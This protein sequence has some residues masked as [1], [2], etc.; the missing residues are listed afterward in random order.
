MQQ[1]HSKKLFQL[2]AYPTLNRWIY[3][4]LTLSGI[5]LMFIV[6]DRMIGIANL[7]LALAFDPFNPK[8]T[9]K[10]RPVYQKRWLIVHLT[11]FYSL[12]MAIFFLQK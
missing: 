12:F 2:L 7:G 3:V 11:V 8:I 6:K 1:H 9:W 10:E 5:V 4:G